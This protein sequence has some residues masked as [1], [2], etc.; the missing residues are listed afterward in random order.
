MKKFFKY[1]SDNPEQIAK[2][3]NLFSWLYLM[4]IR[5]TYSVETYK[6]ISLLD[7]YH[8][9]QESAARDGDAGSW[10]DV[11]DGVM[12]IISFLALIFIWGFT[13]G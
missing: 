5:D 10:Y 12:W 9:S 3:F 6:R 8:I 1:I 4:Y 7:A 11:F 2:Y 13:F